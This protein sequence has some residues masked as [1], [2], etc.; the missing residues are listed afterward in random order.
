[1]VE[2]TRNQ[3]Q[4][5]SGVMNLEDW[6]KSV[7][8]AREGLDI[9]RLRAACELASQAEQKGRDSRTLGRGKEQ[10]SHWARNGRYLVAFERR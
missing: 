9:N 10:L 6:L 4:I 5:T 8:D 1:M 3:R 7:L 2:A